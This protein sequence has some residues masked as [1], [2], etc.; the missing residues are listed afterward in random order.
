MISVLDLHFK[1][2][3]TEN[4][5][6][7]MT[8]SLEAGRLLLL[9]GANGSGKSTLLQLLCGLASPGGGRIRIGDLTSPGM[10]KRIRTRV[11][12]VFQDPGVQILGATVGED[13]LLGA[14]ARKM[15]EAVGHELAER[16]GLRDLWDRPVQDLS[17]GEKRRLCLASAL[18]TGPEVLLMDEPLSGLD[19]PGIQ[20]LRRLIVR[21]R[22][23]GLT[24]IVAS[25]DL[26]P[27]VDLA[28]GLAVLHQG[29]LVRWGIPVEVLDGIEQFGV[30]APCSWQRDRVIGAWK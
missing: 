22:E 12:L 3:G 20:E 5:L 13:L 2:P 14:R 29:D 21:N 1:H 30:R 8:F 7:K 23:Q 15:G 4:G 16:F 11:G 19:Y 10:E 26:E 6:G 9:A 28:D 25:H 27:L 17:G 24:Q 18:V